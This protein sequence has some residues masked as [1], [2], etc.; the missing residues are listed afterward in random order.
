MPVIRRLFSW[1]LAMAALLSFV[2]CNPDLEHLPCSRDANCPSGQS[3]VYGACTVKPSDSED[4]GG[5][6][7]GG[8]SA[9]GSGGSSGGGLASGGGTASGGGIGTG[10]GAALGG[11]TA[12]GGGIGAGGGTALGGGTAS[13]GGIGA[14]GGGGGACTPAACSGTCCGTDCVDISQATAHCGGCFHDCGRGASCSQGICGPANLTIASASVNGGVVA[15][16]TGVYFADGTRLLKCPLDGCTLA[17]TQVW[18]GNRVSNITAGG[19]VVAW[20]GLTDTSRSSIQTC[21]AAA[22]NPITVMSGSA[23]SSVDT[24][25]IFGSRLFYHADSFFA[26][27]YARHHIY[28]SEVQDGGCSGTNS[29]GGRPPYAP[30]ATS[31]THLSTSMDG[32][33]RFETCSFDTGSCF[34]AFPE[35]G[36]VALTAYN[37]LIFYA[38]TGMIGPN[39][40]RMIESCSTAGCASGTKVTNTPLTQD[41]VDMAADSSG[42]YWTLSGDPGSIWMCPGTT[43]T[44]GSRQ[45]AGDQANP[46]SIS[47]Q[48]N[49]V[50]WGVKSADGGF[51]GPRRVAKPIP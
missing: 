12:S 17:P 51:S 5:S 41:V 20:E 47:L 25:R 42:V 13:G 3:C 33:T 35:S 22:C 32:G 27:E 36:V 43:C 30:E 44:G 37:G 28:C 4:G 15:D 10:G 50:Y 45:I 39:P 29:F 38:W 48:G 26:P 1:G 31:V 18:S 11:G 34:P 8:G 24:P 6:T 21:P 7:A 23:A 49:F 14:G 19:G 16:N 40:A 2:R 46:F 9:V